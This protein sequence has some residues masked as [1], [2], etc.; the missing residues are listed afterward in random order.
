ME[1]FEELKYIYNK[2]SFEQ[3]SAYSERNIENVISYF[4]DRHLTFQAGK[5]DYMTHIR[6]SII[7]NE[8]MLAMQK[9]P[10]TGKT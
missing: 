4:Q 3:K 10:L 7:K 5:D 9:I 1:R 6:R 2:K 8:K